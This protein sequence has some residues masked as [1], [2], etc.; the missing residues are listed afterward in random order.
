MGM[1]LALGALIVAFAGCRDGA[2]Q[3]GAIDASLASCLSPNATVIAGADLNALRAAPIF[4]KLPPSAHAFIEQL[5]GVSKAL[6]SYGGSELLVAARGNFQTAPAGA[7]MIAP[8][9][10]I[11]GATE[12]VAAARKRYQAS[13][14]GP[15]ELLARAEPIAAGAQVWIAA[16]GSATFPLSGNFASAIGILRKATFYTVAARIG[17]S[18]SVDL[19]ATAPD[20]NAARAIE[21][22]LRADFT[23]AAAGESK[24]PD[25]VA[26]LRSAKVDRDGVNVHVTLIANAALIESLAEAQHREAEYARAEHGQ[27]GHLRPE[28]IE[29]GAFQE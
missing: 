9:V 14:G 10:A 23:L 16:R 4:A 17:E 25:I 12:Q 11:F 21:E 18:V 7:T 28:H 26:A 20:E 29:A 2:R 1:L 8:G 6:A 3:A 24:H 15:A 19:R 22:T 5:Q 27:R 13:E